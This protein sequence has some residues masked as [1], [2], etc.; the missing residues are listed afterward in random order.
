MMSLIDNISCERY[1][2]YY[3]YVFELYSVPKRDKTNET[4]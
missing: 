1:D 3:N 4:D 2:L